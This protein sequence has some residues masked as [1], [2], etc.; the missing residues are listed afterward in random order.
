M[1]ARRRQLRE[2]IVGIRARCRRLRRLIGGVERQRRRAAERRAH[3]HHR[4]KHIRARQRAPAGDRRSEIVA[5][6]HRDVAVTERVDER[7]HVAHAVERRERRQVVVELHVGAA[8]SAV[9]ALIGRDHVIA[10]LSPAAASRGAS[11]KPSSGNPWISSTAGRFGAFES[12]FERVH[13]DA[14]HAGDHPR[15]N[16]RRNRRRTVG[17]VR[18]RRRLRECERACRAEAASRRARGAAASDLEQFASGH[19]RENITSWMH[20]F[21][22][23]FSS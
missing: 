23:L 3:H 12:R 20:P 8:A 1:L 10:R 11:C 9:A 4:S 19:K 21:A 7:H 15:S 6:D 17:D 14:V 13:R 18:V 16:A 22:Q 5:D 2:L